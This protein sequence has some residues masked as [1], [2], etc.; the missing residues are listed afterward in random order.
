MHA[1]YA[2]RWLLG[3][4]PCQHGRM[5]VLETVGRVLLVLTGLAMAVV[6]TTAWCLFVFMLTGRLP[7]MV[8]KYF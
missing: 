5:D 4:D 8:R 7:W 3:P 2:P 6:L 1:G